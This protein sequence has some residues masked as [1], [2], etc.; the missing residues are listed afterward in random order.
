MTTDV[1]F[2]FTMS[3]LESLRFDRWYPIFRK[4]TIRSEIITLSKEFVKYLLSD[5]VVLPRCDERTLSTQDPRFVAKIVEDDFSDDEEVWSDDDDDNDDDDSRP[6][7]VE[8]ETKIKDSIRRLGGAA[9]A[10]V[11]WSSANDAKWITGSLKCITPGH[12]FL[13]LKSSDFVSQSVTR[14]GPRRYCSDFS[15]DKKEE[16]LEKNSVLV[17]RRWGNISLSQ[18][19]RC[20]VR[21]HRIIA[22]SQRDVFSYY[23]YLESR[24]E[25]VRSCVS[26]FFQ[27]EMIPILKANSTKKIPDSF[28]MDVFIDRKDKVHLI[29]LSVLGKPTDTLLFSFSDLRNLENRLVVETSEKSFDFEIRF[30]RT[31]KQIVPSGRNFYCLP[32]DVLDRMSGKD[33]SVAEIAKEE[34]AKERR[35]EKEK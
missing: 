30:V 26:K 17:L 5:G 32:K 6:V 31:K 3:E 21:N 14:T 11:N 1:E 24:R 16:D 9:F 20:F 10:K 33:T 27:N 19:F 22:L 8:L 29:D 18:E 25:R 28:V 34:V 13:L 35:N 15:E 2:P 4:L 7:F 12:V 23:D